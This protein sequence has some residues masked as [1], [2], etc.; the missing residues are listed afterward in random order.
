MRYRYFIH[1]SVILSTNSY[2]QNLKN[3]INP[4]DLIQYLIHYEFVD[5]A[6]NSLI[7]IFQVLQIFLN[8]VQV[9]VNFLHLMPHLVQNSGQGLVDADDDFQI[10]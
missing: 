6:K 3:I 1:K 2:I 10:G 7:H 5:F 8:S 9:C 4:F